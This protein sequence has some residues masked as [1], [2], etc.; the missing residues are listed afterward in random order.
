MP[1]INLLRSCVVCLL[2]SS[3]RAL[4]W[5]WASLS[6]F[7]HVII[8]IIIMIFVSTCAHIRIYIC[9]SFC[10]L[11]STGCARH[12][13]TMYGIKN[14]VNVAI[15]RGNIFII[16]MPRC[17]ILFIF[18]L[19]FRFFFHS[20]VCTVIHALSVH[21]PRAV[22]VAAT[23][24]LLSLCHRLRL[25]S[26]SSFHSESAFHLNLLVLTMQKQHHP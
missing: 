11:C 9:R 26:L 21:H 23:A 3:P 19:F 18:F 15:C 12:S 6:Y 10:G 25:L 2:F 4:V 7:L 1:V 13:K 22:V 14:V 24:L 17:S 20:L 16:A 8:I 5:A